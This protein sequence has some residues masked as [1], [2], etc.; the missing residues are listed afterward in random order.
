MVTYH[1][2]SY[3]PRSL[4]CYGI[5]HIAKITQTK[6][7]FDENIQGRTPLEAL[8]VEMPDISQYLDFVFYD[9]VW[10]KE[11]AGLGETKLARFVGGSH[12]VGSLLSYW[13]LP[14]MESP[15]NVLR[16]K[17]LSTLTHKRSNAGKDYPSMTKGPQKD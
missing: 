6:G 12:Q 15:C 11:D 16:Y 9:R 10:F 2:Q 5:P 13:V 3:C 14:A 8:T 17:E 7:S 4:W 1:D